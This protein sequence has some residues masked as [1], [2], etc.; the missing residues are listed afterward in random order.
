VYVDPI[1]Y[2][3]A[4]LATILGDAGAG[5]QGLAGGQQCSVGRGVTSHW[6]WG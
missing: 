3:S 4:Y 2:S 6:V 5:L 1:T